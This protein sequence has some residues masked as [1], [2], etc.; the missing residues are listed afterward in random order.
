MRI[1]SMSKGIFILIPVHNRRETTLRGLRQLYQDTTIQNWPDLHLVVIDDG[2]TDGT[3]AALRN[4]FPAVTILRGNGHLWW[5][6]AI[7]KGMEYAYNKGCEAVFWLNDDCPPSAGSLA[8]MHEASVYQGNALIGAACYI[9]ETDVLKPTGAQGRTPVAAKPGEMMPVDEMSGHC[10][11]IPRVV[12]DAIGCPDIQRF[13]HYHGDS[14]YTL[15][16]TRAGFRAYI[17]GDAKVSHPGIIKAKP[18]DFADFQ[19]ATPIQTFKQIFL[20]QKSLYYWPTQFFYNTEKYGF[21]QGIGLFSL[22][23]IRWLIKWVWLNTV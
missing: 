16:A 23:S 9:A 14:S 21:W 11:Y 2:S 8:K 12:M 15:Q 13:P 5:T 7:R 18:E 19:K 22:K 6:G 17:L 1:I 4:E 3:E 20:S 10:V